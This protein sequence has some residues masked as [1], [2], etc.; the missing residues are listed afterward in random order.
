[1]DEEELYARF[2][3]Q[4]IPVARGRVAAAL[5]AAMRRDETTT[6]T[7]VRELHTLA[8]EAGLL[9]LVELVPL[10][11]D[12]EHKAKHL[13]VTSDADVE[14]MLAALRVLESKVEGIAATTPSGSPDID[15]SEHPGQTN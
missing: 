8:G 4:F 5:A 12:G 2:L 6:P 7:I 13:D 14:R 10:V 11:R 9:G 3:P 15:D 1:M